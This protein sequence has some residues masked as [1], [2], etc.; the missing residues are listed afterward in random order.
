MITLEDRKVDNLYFPIYINLER[1][2]IDL[3]SSI[4]FNDEQSEV[5][6]LKIA[7]LI[8]R[9]SIELESIAKNIF[10]KK[11]KSKPKNPGKCFKW[12]ETNWKLS[13]KSISII[14]P[15]PNTWW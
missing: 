2:I 8:I 15:L 13:N 6:S 5:Y 4:H 7:D 12:L 3:A 10:I 1:E 11:T 14:S 9:S